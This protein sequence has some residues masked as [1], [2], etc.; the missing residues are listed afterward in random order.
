MMKLRMKRAA[1]IGLVV[2]GML[3][4]AVALAAMNISTLVRWSMT[5]SSPF[6]PG[7]S[8]PA[9]DYSDPANWSAPPELSE[10][11]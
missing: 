6:D 4:I 8:P 1:G 11:P 10:I 3:L 9:P 5:P 7:A 2:L